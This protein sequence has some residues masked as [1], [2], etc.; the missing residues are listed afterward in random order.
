MSFILKP[1]RQFDA[2][3]IKNKYN[4]KR[5][6][7]VFLLG[8]SL[9]YFCFVG[10]RGYIAMDD[11]SS[12][13]LPNISEGVMP[14]YSFLLNLLHVIFGEQ[15]LQIASYLQGILASV[16]VTVFVRYLVRQFSLKIWESYI[17]W[18]ATLLPFS[19][20]MPEYVITHVIY[21]EAITY[22]L[23]Y[24]Y[25]ITLLNLVYR[26][27]KQD[28]LNVFN[29]SV[30]MALIRS[31]LLLLLVVWGVFSFYYF[32][33]KNKK[34]WQGF[35]KASLNMAVGV[36]FGVVLVYSIRGLYARTIGENFI[37]FYEKQEA[38][39][40]ETISAESEVVVDT[41]S[42]ETG[43]SQFGSALVVRGFFEAEE[44]DVKYY[45]T[46]EMR[47]IFM[48]LYTRCSEKGYL[49]TEV[50]HGLRMWEEMGRDYI[51]REAGDVL[52]EYYSEMGMDMPRAERSIWFRNTKIKLAITEICVHPLRFL[53]HCIRL[54]I[55]GFIS[56]IF[57]NIFNIYLACH[58]IVLFLYGSAFALAYY[59]V[60]KLS[61]VKEGKMMLTSLLC[62]L[63]FVTVT[64]II[65]YGM[66]RYFLYQMGVYYCAYY[67]L[68]RNYV[69]HIWEWKKQKSI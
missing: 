52:N 48:R 30:V 20:E 43:T 60:K 46:E 14:G 56:C 50:G 11:T 28:L 37:M 29:M 17:L 9:L 33:K 13:I 18:L 68:V 22:S 41:T 12:F 62:C 42:V 8:A 31:Q 3:V 24:I 69:I 1:Y 5:M 44:E 53:Y 10:Q 47:E 55:P 23:Y 45:Q 6:N 15:Y 59:A 4:Y 65:F 58:I 66:Q 25:F 54:M 2:K 51:F 35:I 32:M 39:T 61:Y 57:F 21:T 16:C 36:V 64:N 27:R 34:K 63:I 19:I 26:L 49:Y 40:G 67:I 38:K 7:S